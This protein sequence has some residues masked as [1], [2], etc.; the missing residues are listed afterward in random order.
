VV[1]PTTAGRLV[2]WLEQT[3]PTQ[4]VAR[5]Q[6]NQFIFFEND[7]S[8]NP[9]PRGLYFLFSCLGSAILYLGWLG[10]SK[11]AGWLGLSKW[12]GWLGLSKWAGLR[13]TGSRASST[14]GVGDPQ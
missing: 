14:T 7:I 3:S 1:V 5:P 10:V 6:G 13:W 11:W 8:I 12:A 9:V 2:C 4:N